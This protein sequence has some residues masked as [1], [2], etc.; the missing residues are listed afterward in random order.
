MSNYKININKPKPD[1][2]TIRKYQNFDK[3]YEEYRVTTRFEFWK[4]LYRKPTY[5]AGLVAAI[6]I[7]FLVFDTINEDFQRENPWVMSPPVPGMEP[8]F[9]VLN[10]D[11][12]EALTFE[13]E[14]G[15]KI[16]VPEDAFVTTEGKEVE[17]EVE[18][19][20]REF[21]DQIDLFL[22]GVPARYDS[23]NISR[24]LE[25][26]GCMEISA[27][28]NGQPL[29]LRKGKSMEI[30]FLANDTSR[31]FGVFALNDE[32]DNWNRQGR[33]QM[34]LADASVGR[35][36]RPERPAS[37]LILDREEDILI[38]KNVSP[39]VAKPG[40]PFGVKIKNI[41][42]F[43]EFRGFEK[44]YWEYL[45]MEGSVNPWTEGLVGESSVWNDVRVRK[46]GPR[47]YELRFGR[48]SDNGGIVTKTVF[49]TPM[50]EA[51]SLAQAES[52]YQ[53]R[54][55]AW[56]EAL[57]QRTELAEQRKD[58]EEKMALAR[59]EY[60]KYLQRLKAWEESVSGDSVIAEVKAFR[61]FAVSQTGVYNIATPLV[62]PPATATVTLEKQDE[63]KTEDGGNVYA[64]NPALNALFP[65]EKTKD[66]RYK[67]NFDTE[68]D[69]W[70]LTADKN[71]YLAEPPLLKGLKNGSEVIWKPEPVLQNSPASL[72]SLILRSK[73]P[74]V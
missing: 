63:A 60:E 24:P 6:A 18:I 11:A 51:R 20:Y 9:M 37:T 71:V 15:S 35:L 8:A 52:L 30:A 31:R 26:L 67:V 42:D 70:L 14:S 45:N 27:W 62:N 66:G 43:P 36:P 74:T 47:Q 2:D 72:K 22:A 50:F 69:W 23:A 5:F 19:R 73:L 41:S 49:A 38:P 40:K 54:Y 56:E 12:D 4:Q 48:I 10:V 3:L 55:K 59:R 58:Y 53:E 64:I 32:K 29:A 33:D 68:G 16:T 44:V 13:A 57:Q 21:R 39:I 28:Q 25:F 61:K 7:I 65:A 1:T 46:T 34:L 17:G